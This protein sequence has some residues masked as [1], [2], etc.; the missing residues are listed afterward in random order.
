MCKG[1]S[2]PLWR[3]CSVTTMPC[4]VG[5]LFPRRPGPGCQAP[6]PIGQSLGADSLASIRATVSLLLYRAVSFDGCLWH[7]HYRGTRGRVVR[8]F[9]GSDRARGNHQRPPFDPASDPRWQHPRRR[10]S[11]LLGTSG[12]VGGMS[13]GAK[14]LLVRRTPRL[15]VPPPVPPSVPPPLPGLQILHRY[16]LRHPAVRR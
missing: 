12:E 6:V 8:V 15:P 1:T 5:P 11:S 3:R 14:L 4:S 13:A 9:R 10:V 7:D 2:T 16:H